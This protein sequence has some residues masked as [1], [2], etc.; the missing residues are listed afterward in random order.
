MPFS[1]ASWFHRKRVH[2]EVSLS[3]RP[4]SAHRVVNPYHAVLITHDA[5]SCKLVRQYE[6]QRILASAAPRLPVPGC[7]APRCRCRYIHCEDRRSGEDRR[8]SAAGSHAYMDG[9]NRRHSQGRRA[10]DD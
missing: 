1:L 2:A 4:V 5:S 10:G 3:G 9:R 7:A 6:G 8:E